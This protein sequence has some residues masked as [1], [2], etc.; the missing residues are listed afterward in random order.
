[1]PLN[2]TN[3]RNVE[4]KFEEGLFKEHGKERAGGKSYKCQECPKQF[5]HKNDFMSASTM[6]KNLEHVKHA[7]NVSA[8]NTIWLKTCKRM[9]LNL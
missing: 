1:M 4:K 9:L 7:I 2:H 3:V 6:E 5:H 8:E